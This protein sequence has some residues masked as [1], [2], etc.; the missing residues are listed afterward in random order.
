M[1]EKEFYKTD[2]DWCEELYIGFKEFRLAKKKLQNI[3]IDGKKLIEIIV[4]GVPAKTYYKVNIAILVNKISSMAKKAKLEWP[5]RPNK[6]GQKGQSIYKETKTTTKT[7]TGEKNAEIKISEPS[8]NNND[9][10][11]TD[12]LLREVKKRYSFTKKKTEKQLIKEYEE[13]NRI[14]RLDE[15]DYQ[16]MLAV[17]NFSQTDDFWKQNIRSVKSLRKSFETLLI[18][19][20]SKA[21]ELK[22]EEPLDARR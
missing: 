8:F 3:E 21:K 14:H 15:F 16:T 20:E 13:M 11:L 19:A 17:I 7:T 9:R 6:N 2:N 1:D 10:K 5:K 22:A 12:Y 18:Q 4:K